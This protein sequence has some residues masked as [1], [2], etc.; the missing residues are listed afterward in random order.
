MKTKHIL[1]LIIRLLVGGIL[2]YAGIVKLMNMDMTIEAMA[3]L[4]LSAAVLW[5]VAI[6]ETLAG[7]G[8]VFGVF[9]QVAAAGAA[10][11]MAGAVYYTGGKMMDT[12]FLLIGSLILI[13]TGSGKY[14]LR[15]CACSIKDVAPKQTTPVTAAQAP[16]ST[17]TPVATPVAPTEPTNPQV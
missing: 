9:T 15:P 14:A 8:I 13:Y 4:G 16:I 5:I 12:I 10:I 7:L 6:G 3:P 2:A 11:I 1:L 17:P